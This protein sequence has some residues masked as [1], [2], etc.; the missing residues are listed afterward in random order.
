[1]ISDG[2]GKAREKQTTAQNSEPK[3]EEKGWTLKSWIGVRK[4]KS[5]TDKGEKSANQVIIKTEKQK[6]SHKKLKREKKANK[7]KQKQKGRPTVCVC[8]GQ[9]VKL[10]K[11]NE[12]RGK[13]V[14][15][16]SWRKSRLSFKLTKNVAL[17]DH[18][19]NQVVW[20]RFFAT[21]EPSRFGFF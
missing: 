1:M 9:S 8:V 7:R 14:W 11:K 19:L 6:I 5:D 13:E 12:T 10:D 2:C 15:R 21:R 16:R 17:A 3:T 4:E 18:K 20:R